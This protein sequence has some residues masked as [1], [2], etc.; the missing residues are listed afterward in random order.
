MLEGA[1]LGGKAIRQLLAPRLG[2]WLAGRNAFFMGY[3][4]ATGE[5][6]RAFT[7]ACDAF[8]RSYSTGERERALTA[9]VATF[10][11]LRVW[12]GD[13]GVAAGAAKA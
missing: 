8:G 1:T 13:Q 7:Q 3:G 2:D 12:L 6:W 9:A 10:D 5:K 4:P 11:S